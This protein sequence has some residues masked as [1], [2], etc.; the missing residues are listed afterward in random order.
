MR[1]PNEVANLKTE[2]LL[3]S[4]RGTFFPEN[5]TKLLLKQLFIQNKFVQLLLILLK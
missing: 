1:F 5:F 2:T 3:K 4:F